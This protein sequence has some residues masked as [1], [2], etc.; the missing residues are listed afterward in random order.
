MYKKFFTWS[1]YLLLNN[2]N[3]IFFI[4]NTFSS[5]FNEDEQNRIWN[6]AV[7]K[8]T[9]QLIY[10]VLF[11]DLFSLLYQTSTAITKFDYNSFILICYITALVLSVRRWRVAQG[12]ETV[13]ITTHKNAPPLAPT[14]Y[15]L[16][17]LFI[18]ILLIPPALKIKCW[19]LYNCLA[20]E[21]AIF[22][23]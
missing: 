1:D 17:C 8:Y 21:S 14:C 7:K 5:F 13:K 12:Q 22:I 4:K 2:S 11:Y 15:L 20:T 9:V 23:N 6:V 19:F 3:G 18:A 16:I 10:Y